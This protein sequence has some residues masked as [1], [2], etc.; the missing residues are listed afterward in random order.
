MQIDRQT[1]IAAGHV[2]ATIS[3]GLNRKT[4]AI[5]LR[6]DGNGLH[7]ARVQGG[8]WTVRC[9][10]PQSA[11]LMAAAPLFPAS[12]FNELADA[13]SI[14]AAVSVPMPVS[15]SAPV[16]VT[17]P[18]PVARPLPAPARADVLDSL[19]IAEA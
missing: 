19:S 17:I 6:E 8:G 4:I 16:Q 15:L 1:A 2:M 5:E 10:T 18:K 9:L 3:H 7:T 12:P 13:P 11:I 14:P